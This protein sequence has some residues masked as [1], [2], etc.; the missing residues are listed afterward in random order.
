MKKNIIIL[1]SLLCLLAGCN[2]EEQVYDRIDASVYYQNEASVK[3]AVAAIYGN[4]ARSY[5]EYFGYL[6][7]FSADQIVWRVWNGGLWGYDE[8]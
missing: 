1:C 3:G 5:L 7:E 2:M 4:A 8:G 6:N